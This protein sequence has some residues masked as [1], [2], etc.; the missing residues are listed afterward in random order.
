MSGSPRGPS[1]SSPGSSRGSGRPSAA[2]SC[3]PAGPDAGAP[4]TIA[5]NR[6]S[7][8]GCDISPANAGATRVSVSI[9]VAMNQPRFSATVPVPASGIRGIAV[10]TEATCA[11][12]ACASRSSLS[13]KELYSTPSATCASLAMSRT[14]SPALP[15]SP[16]SRAAVAI[17]YSRR[18]RAPPPSPSR[19]TAGF[20]GDIAPE[21]SDDRGAGEHH[22]V[23]EQHQPAAPLRQ[24]PTRAAEVGAVERLAGVKRQPAR[25][26]GSDDLPDD[27]L[28]QRDP[29][30]RGR[31]GTDQVA[32]ER[33]KADADDG[34]REAGGEAT[35]Q[36]QPGV[37]A[38]KPE[39]A[40]LGRPPRGRDADRD[41]RRHQSGGRAD[42]P[43]DGQ[44]GGDHPAPVR[45]A[46]ERVGNRAVPVLARDRDD[47]E[48][49]GDD[50]GQPRVG[51]RLTLHRGVV[52][53][54]ARLDEAGDP[55]HDDQWPGGQQQPGAA[56]T[57]DLPEPTA[58]H[59]GAPVSLRR[60][61]SSAVPVPP[62]SS[63]G[64]ANRSR[65]ALTITT[66]SA[67]CAT[68]PST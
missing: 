25:Q 10:M 47:A 11:S 26:P 32:D 41:G 14:A 43:V 24:Q 12:R 61:H 51:E 36:R 13:A 5:W 33:A 17:R 68:S 22:G 56:H 52:H 19:S 50:R 16:I 4:P 1:R 30:Q 31:H 40:A 42:Q 7:T 37:R 62:S 58:D 9:P 20:L 39:A 23:T 15:R 53:I 2:P 3:G 8:P 45:A 65:P 48:E 35:A 54:A 63:S 29:R 59:A 27:A 57:R 67:V 46:Q 6:T 28:D 49:Q 55:G 64:P 34:E 60:A 66:R 18:S 38:G 21:C 44:L